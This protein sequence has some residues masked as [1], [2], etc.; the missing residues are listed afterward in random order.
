MLFCWRPQRQR[1]E[2]QQNLTFHASLYELFVIR[3]LDNYM[4]G[5][6]WSL[7]QPQQD[8]VTVTCDCEWLKE[9]IVN[10]VEFT[11]FKKTIK[12]LINVGRIFHS[13]GSLLCM[14]WLLSEGMIYPE[15][16]V[17]ME[18]SSPDWELTR[19]DSSQNES[20]RFIGWLIKLS[21]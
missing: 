15:N 13:T 5:G 10:Y 18:S 14:L 21:W 1:T 6:S 9:E 4:S 8:M 16:P 7:T 20:Y 3:V 19:Q 12:Y 11:I 17:P 2:R